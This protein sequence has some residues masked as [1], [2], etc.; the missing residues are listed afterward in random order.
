MVLTER[1]GAGTTFA[2]YVVMEERCDLSRFTFTGY[3]SPTQWDTVVP[4]LDLVLYPLRFGT[5]NW[6]VFEL[7][8]RGL[9]VVASNRCYMP[10]VI[11]DGVNGYLID[12]DDID[13]WVART[14]HLLDNP[15]VRAT[16]ARGAR[17]GSE[18][19]RPEHVAARYLEFFEAV[20][21]A[22]GAQPVP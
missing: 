2:E 3:L 10:E 21:R 14:V 13:A 1:Y 15:Q 7:L 4:T 16:I 9:V 12:L 11:E 22:H 18:R 5:W 6:G 20:I 19:F 17:R 8:Q